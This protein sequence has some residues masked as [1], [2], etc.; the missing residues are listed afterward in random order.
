ML[1]YEPEQLNMLEYEP[2]QLNQYMV[3]EPGCQNLYRDKV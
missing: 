3:Y 1:E 2:E